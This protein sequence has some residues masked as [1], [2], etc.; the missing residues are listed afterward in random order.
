MLPLDLPKAAIDIGW[1]PVAHEEAH[2]LVDELQRELPD[3]HKL[4]GLMVQALA[5]RDD[6]DDVLYLVQ[7]K[8]PCLAQVH[9]TYSE[10]HDPQWPYCELY[11][12]V[13][14]WLAAKLGDEGAGMSA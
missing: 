7:A 14:A 12:S 4:K 6:R 9:L 2:Q 10:E 1:R 8:P 5:R 11:D 3:R 13:D